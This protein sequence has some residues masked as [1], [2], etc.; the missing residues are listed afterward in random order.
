MVIVG[1][2]TAPPGRIVKRAGTRT[3]TPAVGAVVVALDRVVVAVAAV[4]VVVLFVGGAL[5]VAPE[6]AWE[7]VV[8]TVV[9]AGATA[10]GTVFVDEVEV[11]FAPPQPATSTSPTRTA[12]SLTFAG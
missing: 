2:L 9:D 4:V 8:A 1:G 6:G 11:D 12:S 5:V 7:R 10:G 3:L